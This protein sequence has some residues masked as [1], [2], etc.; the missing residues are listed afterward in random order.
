MSRESTGSNGSSPRWPWR[1]SR[2]FATYLGR[3]AFNQARRSLPHA[4]SIVI[5]T[6]P[7]GWIDFSAGSMAGSSNIAASEDGGIGS[8]SGTEALEDK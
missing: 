6:P 1:R 5:T 8:L 4:N 3:T 7:P 2:I